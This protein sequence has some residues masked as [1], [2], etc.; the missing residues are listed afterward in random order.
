MLLVSS[1]DFFL[2]KIL[3]RNSIR[4]SDGLDPD[5][6]RHSVGIDLGSNRLQRHKWPLHIARKESKND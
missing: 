5:Q 3:F 4:V 6:A 2:K 1:I